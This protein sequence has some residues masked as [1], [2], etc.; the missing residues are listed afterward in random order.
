MKSLCPRH[1]PPEAIDLST[2]RWRD[3]PSTSLFLHKF[4]AARQ[5]GAS[6]LFEYQNRKEQFMRTRRIGNWFP[7]VIVAI[8]ILG[9]VG[10]TM[11]NESLTRRQLKVMRSPE[12][13]SRFEM[14]ILAALDSVKQVAITNKTILDSIGTAL[15]SAVETGGDRG[16]ANVDIFCTLYKKDQKIEFT[17]QYS[18]YRGWQIELAAKSIRSDYIIN[19]VQ[20][21][22]DTGKY[23]QLRRN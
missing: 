1:V 4:V 22:I 8:I 15:R 19:F 2:Y 10:G 13:V 23:T 21:Y 6:R 9:R 3:S 14:R 20:S 11:S 5:T 18:I 16:A 12:R 17:I 7:V